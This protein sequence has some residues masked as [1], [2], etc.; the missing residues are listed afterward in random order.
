MQKSS[1]YKV[2][3]DYLENFMRCSHT[4][5]AHAARCR[6]GTTQMEVVGWCASPRMRIDCSFDGG[7]PVC[8]DLWLEKRESY[9]VATLHLCF[10]C[11]LTQTIRPLEPGRGNLLARWAWHAIRQ[12]I[13]EHED[14]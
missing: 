9:R 1:V 7:H 5:A 8:I 11:I 3:R 4:M 6:S 13:C 14:L 12:P 10:E 2:S